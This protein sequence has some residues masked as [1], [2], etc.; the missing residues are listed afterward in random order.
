V[1]SR[2][3]A[4]V[5][6]PLQSRRS[7]PATAAEAFFRAS[8]PPYRL[9]ELLVSIAEQELTGRLLLQSDTGERTLFFQRGFPVFAQSSQFGERLGALGVRYGL[10]DRDDVARALALSRE[11][12]TELGRALLELELV[13]GADLFRLLSAQLVEQLAASCG[14]A[15]T[16]VRFILEPRVS[17][18]VVLLRVHPLTAVL[19]AVRRMPLSEQHKMLEAV[20]SRRVTSAGFGMPT[21]TWLNAIGFIGA[22]ELLLEGE[23]TVTLIRSRLMA[24]V[25]SLVQQE[26]EPKRAPLFNATDA[27][28]APRLSARSVADMLCLT[29]LLGGCLKL[30]SAAAQTEH[31]DALPNTAAG[32]QAML[33]R[34]S[35]HPLP[36]LPAGPDARTRGELEQA[37]HEYLFVPRDA[38]TEARLAIWGPGA[39]VTASD[40]L[41]ELLTLYLTLKPEREPRAILALEPDS[42]RDETLAAHAQYASFLTALAHTDSG[43]LV[44]CKVLELRAH[45]NDAVRALVPDALDDDCA[46]DADTDHELYVDHSADD[47]PALAAVPS[48]PRAPRVP[49]IDPAAALEPAQPSAGAPR[50]DETPIERGRRT[51]QP[52]T[53]PSAPDPSPEDAGATK[54][55][56][57]DSW[58]KRPE[59]MYRRVD[60]LLRSGDYEGVCR[61]LDRRAEIAELPPELELARSVAHHE[62]KRGGGVAGSSVTLPLLIATWCLGMAVGWALRH[63]D[64][65]VF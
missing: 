63:L 4:T 35:D 15:H 53:R 12:G 2:A 41:A 32:V 44:R 8:V 27:A 20:Q 40:T 5:S 51:S 21:L 23:P 9:G 7:E 1:S 45:I 30:V 19:G 59:T 34:A 47:E 64:L 14:S 28:H 58:V 46:D 37:I 31:D 6:N 50:D 33:N 54:S 16:R 36:N 3:T 25:G 56:R 57:E 17:D 62:L 26:L 24:H 13:D 60:A 43:P 18:H 38:L 52:S 29:L 65:L 55:G 49:R 48:F 11:H 10:F 42:R 22:P 39:E 61:L